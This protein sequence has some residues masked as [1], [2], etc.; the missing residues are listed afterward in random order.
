MSLII[1]WDF[2]TGD[3]V[4][5]FMPMIIWSFKAAPDKKQWRY[6]YDNPDNDRFVF[7][8]VEVT[9]DDGIQRTAGWQLAVQQEP[10]HDIYQGFRR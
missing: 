7:R 5:L 1:P 10:E 3:R 2:M 4:I 9:V 8:A 6:T